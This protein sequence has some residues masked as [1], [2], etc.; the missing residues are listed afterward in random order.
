MGSSRNRI[1]PICHHVQ[2]SSEAH[3][4]SYQIGT[5]G[6]SPRDKWPG[7]EADHSPPPSAKVKNTRNYTST[8]P[9]VFMVWC[10]IKHRDNF[11]EVPPC[12]RKVVALKQE[13]FQNVLALVYKYFRYVIQNREFSSIIIKMT[14]SA[15][16]HFTLKMEAANFSLNT[17]KPDTRT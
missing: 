7:Y 15:V 6:S 1:F 3:P 5:R 10:L 9:Y 16:T 14:T 8:P 2:V 4:T 11:S 12:S 13:C 17:G